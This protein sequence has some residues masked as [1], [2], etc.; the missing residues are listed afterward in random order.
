MDD[1]RCRHSRREKR[2][3][4]FSNGQLNVVEQCLDCGT[5]ICCVPKVKWVG[6]VNPSRLPEYD[7]TIRQ[8]YWDER[9][10]ASRQEWEDRKQRESEEWWA[11][12]EAHMR[13][14]AWQAIRIKVLRRDKYVCQGCGQTNASQVHHLTYKRLGREMMFDLVSVCEDCHAAIHAS[15]GAE[16]CR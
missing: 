5:Q 13:S 4:V 3:R 6:A 12:W 8:R 15:R 2:R 7:D 1:Q 11:V 10:A 14:P 9:S 16:S